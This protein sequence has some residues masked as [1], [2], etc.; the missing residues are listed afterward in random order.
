METAADCNEATFFDISCAVFR[1]FAPNFNRDKVGYGLVIFSVAAVDCY[2]EFE[3]AVPVL[4]NLRSGSAVSL[5]IK[6]TEFIIK[7]P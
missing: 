5:P 7:P 4:I 1:L 3:I 2:C 6:V